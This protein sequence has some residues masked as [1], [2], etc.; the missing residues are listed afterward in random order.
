M[1]VPII[2]EEESLYA[3]LHLEKEASKEEI[4]KAYRRACL[5][6]HPDKVPLN[7]TENEKANAK[8]DF[9][10]ISIAY[11]ILTDD[12]ARRRYDRTGD[13]QTGTGPL[14]S[15]EGDV[16]WSDWIRSKYGE[17]ITKE[18]IDRFEQSYKGTFCAPPDVH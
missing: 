2:D 13:W 8:R 1:T 7:A 17:P 18:D 15:E 3:L 11:N 5:R 9:E 4:G 10:R 16:D 12:A 14:D 6:C